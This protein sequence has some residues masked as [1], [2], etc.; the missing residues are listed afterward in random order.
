MSEFLIRKIKK[1]D[2]P[3]MESIIRSVFFEL[4]IPLQGT[5]FEDPETSKMY[6][7]Y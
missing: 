1:Q 4:N 7:A 5:A 3:Q 2:N 6:E